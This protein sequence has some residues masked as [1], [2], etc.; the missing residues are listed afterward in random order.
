YIEVPDE[1]FETLGCNVLTLAPLHVLV[2]AGSP[3]T[4]ARLE[5]AGCRVDAYSGSEISHNRAG[6][7][8]CLTRPILR[9]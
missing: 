6:G 8:T 7:P 2:C 5:A 1:E 9:A 3:I 4:R